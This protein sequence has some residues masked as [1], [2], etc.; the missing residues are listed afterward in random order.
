M[1]DFDSC[2]IPDYMRDGI[3]L[4][5]EHGILPGSFMTAVLENKLVQA[6]GHADDTNSRLLKNY[7]MFLYN[8]MP[9]QSWGSPEKVDKWAKARQK[10]QE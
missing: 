3:T 7:A 9:S 4:Y 6:V 8:E 2:D 10:G 1:M 5:V